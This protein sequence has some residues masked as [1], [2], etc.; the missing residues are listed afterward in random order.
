MYNRRKF[1]RD[2]A[3][4]GALM[5]I[6]K[7]TLAASN[8]VNQPIVISTWDFGVAANADAWKILSNNG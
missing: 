5:A 3:L 1:I 8:N 2:T 7:N 4:S 6:S